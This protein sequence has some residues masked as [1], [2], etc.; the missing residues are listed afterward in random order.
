MRI[1]RWF[2]LPIFCVVSMLLHVGVAYVARGAGT[3]WRIP[4]SRSIEVS[5]EAAPLPKPHPAA[6]A[7]APKVAEPKQAIARTPRIASIKP[8][9]VHAPRRVRPAK[10]REIRPIEPVGAPTPT[11]APRTVRTAVALPD[12][13]T[14]EIPEA[15]RRVARPALAF[16]M[17]RKVREHT[18]ADAGGSLSPA[19]IYGGHDGLA[20]PESPKEDLVYSGGGR[21]GAN[22]PNAP[23]TTG[24]GGG[25]SILHVKGDNPLG[26]PI[27]EDKPGEGPGLAGGLGTGSKGGVG[28][29]SGKG[30]GTDP[31]SRVAIGSIHR[32]TGPGIGAAPGGAEN[33]TKAP[34]GGRG[35]GADLPGTGG[36]GTGYGR[37]RGVHLGDGPDEALP[38]GRL[39]GV[40]FANV[41]GLLGPAGAPGGGKGAP[42]TGPG[43][44]AV[45]TTRQASPAEGPIH[46]IY[47]L[48]ISG[49]MQDGAKILKAQE[50]LRRALGELRRSDTF[51]V[52]LFK[53][54]AQTFMEDS[55]P[56]TIANISNARSY[57]TDIKLGNG[58]NISEAME[59]ALGMNG[60]TQIYL[61][62]DGEPNG[63]I[64]DFAELR[65]F[66]REHNT[67]KVAI[68]TVAFG[69]GENF[70]GMLLLKGIAE[71]NGGTYKYVNM[72]K[73]GRQRNLDQ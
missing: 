73:F 52:I 36:R 69:M 39:R 14:R 16:R 17:H 61:M 13:I 25:A 58:T 45:F 63:G 1:E 20:A 64:M 70:P 21:G 29:A 44:G 10:V 49:S 22:L 67:R 66:I 7:P 23:P 48:D 12:Q 6:K 65:R 43:R 15:T 11:P 50:E 51:N 3:S 34:G 72:L 26:D 47:A 55:V 46:I 68:H 5:F 40:P 19:P 56:A 71:D 41:G 33:G 32:S 18:R 57:I 54:H 2:W 9:P 4:E 24:G 37:G 28:F 30:I 53:R 38:A 60:I 27:P 35:L 8:A 62:S 42:A 31:D 59:L